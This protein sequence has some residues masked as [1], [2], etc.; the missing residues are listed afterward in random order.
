MGPN[1]GPGKS[2]RLLD[3]NAAGHGWYIDS[4][5][6]SNEEFLPTADANIWQAK[7]GSA[8]EGK[9][10]VLS[11]LLHEYGHSLGLEHS[12]AASDAMAATLKPGE[13]RLFTADELAQVERFN[14]SFAALDASPQTPNQPGSPQV[15]NTS[16]L[17]GLSLIRRRSAMDTGADNLAAANASLTSGTFGDNTLADATS[18][19]RSGTVT[20][21]AN[22]A[23][24]LENPS[25]QTALRQ[26]FTLGDQ[27]RYLRF[28][29]QNDLHTTTANP[30]G[31]NDASEAALLDA[32]NTH[33]FEVLVCQK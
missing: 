22:G 4:T 25:Q 21:S 26:V 20:F 7:P 9:M 24:L 11:V 2:D 5:P 23:Q 32:N 12:T 6:L 19:T 3:N 17:L 33:G 1:D 10:D 15:P 8:A 16:L 27:D 28:T 29:L 31:P 13:R 14:M 30:S 18:W